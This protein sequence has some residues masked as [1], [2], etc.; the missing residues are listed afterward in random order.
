MNSYRWEEL[1]IGLRH[2]FSAEITSEMLEG[3][4]AISG[5]WNPMHHDAE[6]ARKAGFPGVVVYGMLTSSLYSQLVGMYLP[7]RFALLHGIT[8]DFKALAF[9]GDQLEVGG[10]IVHLTDAYRQIQIKATI[11]R[12]ETL[13]SRA[14]IRVGLHER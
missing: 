13:I 11:H 10:E 5:D 2:V 9:V 1:Q 6:F 14:T 8:I 4:A 12:E 7:G 3:F